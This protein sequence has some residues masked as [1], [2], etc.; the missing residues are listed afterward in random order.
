VNIA[1]EVSFGGAIYKVSTYK[2][3]KGAIWFMI[4][5]SFVGGY[6]VFCGNTQPIPL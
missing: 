5:R 6:Q 4:Q 3:S 2:N 1:L